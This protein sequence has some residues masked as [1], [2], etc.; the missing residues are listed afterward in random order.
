MA[1]RG[2]VSTEH[3][4]RL[5]GQ[6]HRVVVR[7]RHLPV[8]VG[9]PEKRE[10]DADLRLLARPFL[11]RASEQQVELL[12]GAAELDVGL[13]GDGVVGLHH[14]VEELDQ[15]D[16]PVRR[17]SLGE[18]VPLEHPGHG[19]P[20]RQTQHV[21]E[22]E[23]REPLAVA[24]DFREIGVENP[25]YLLLVG[26]EVVLDLLPREHRPG[27]APPRMFPTATEQLERIRDGVSEIV[28]EA[29]LLDKLE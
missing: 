18:V 6:A 28:P 3:L 16:R 22:I 7:L 25:K 29:E 21:L 5:V 26:I 27:L 20:R 23:E 4:G 14:R 17:E 2:S 10:Q 9:A 13:E 15:G 24:S 12:I 8:S 11:K 1:A 19:V